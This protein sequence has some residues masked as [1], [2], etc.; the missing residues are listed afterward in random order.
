MSSHLES[1]DDRQTRVG[2]RETAK[3]VGIFGKRVETTSPDSNGVEGESKRVG[4]DF[5]TLIIKMRR[6]RGQEKEIHLFTTLW[7]NS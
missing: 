3:E 6:D 7:K 1:K 5:D 2:I 4:R